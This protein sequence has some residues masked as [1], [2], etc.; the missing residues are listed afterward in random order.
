MRI[1]CQKRG[2]AASWC[3]SS[4]ACSGA[5][6]SAAAWICLRVASCASAAVCSRLARHGHPPPPC[7]PPSGIPFPPAAHPAL[8]AR[9]RSRD[10][11]AGRARSPH[12]CRRRPARPATAA[13]PRGARAAASATAGCLP[14]ARRSAARAAGGSR[15]A[16]ACCAT[17]STVPAPR[18]YA[19][20]ASGSRAFS[21][22]RLG[23]RVF[24]TRCFAPP[25]RAAH[26]CSAWV[27]CERCSRQEA[28]WARRSVCWLSSRLRR[29]LDVAQL[30][31]VPRH[32][33]VCRVDARPARRSSASPAP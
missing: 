15:P 31:F 24:A 11:A 27:S 20:S 5:F 4:Q 32:F 17:R 19:R 8:P 7:W 16:A 30:R 21:V 9:R 1:F 10:P 3:R 6:S 14:G 12:S 28:S 26:M 33:G 13:R 25:E 2:R 29:L 22:A 23:L 18:G